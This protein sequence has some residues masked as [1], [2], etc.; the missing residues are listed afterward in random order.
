V[1]FWSFQV[2]LIA[3]GVGINPLA[4]IYFHIFDL[5]RQGKGHTNCQKVHLVFSARNSDELL[6]KS[7]FDEITKQEPDVFSVNYIQTREAD[8][9]DNRLNKDKLSSTLEANFPSSKDKII[10]YLCG[11]PQMIKDLNQDLQALG[12]PKGNIKYE[13]WW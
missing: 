11:P 8:S 2:L 6:F 9:S 5:I 13:L 12:I 10:C 4:S 1:I 7:K 3:G